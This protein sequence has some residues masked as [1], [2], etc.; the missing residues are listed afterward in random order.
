MFC[1]RT[2]TEGNI[3]YSGTSAV[4]GIQDGEVKVYGLLGRGSKELLVVNTDAVPYAKLVHRPSPSS[5]GPQRSLDEAAGNI[6][7][8]RQSDL[9]LS[10]S[11]APPPPDSIPLR[12]RS[13]NLSPF[14]VH[15]SA[16]AKSDQAIIPEPEPAASRL[17]LPSGEAGKW[18]KVII[19][20]SGSRSAQ[21]SCEYSAKGKNSEACQEADHRTHPLLS[22]P[23][24]KTSKQNPRPPEDSTPYPYSHD[25]LDN[26]TARWDA[27]LKTV[28]ARIDDAINVNGQV[29]NSKGSSHSVDNWTAAPTR[30]KSR[31]PSRSRS[32]ARSMSMDRESNNTI[33]NGQDCERSK[34]ALTQ[35]QDVL[36]SQ[37]VALKPNN[38]D[39]LLQTVTGRGRAP[40]RFS[41]LD[42]PERVG[43]PKRSTSADST[44]NDIL[45]R[46]DRNRDQSNFVRRSSSQPKF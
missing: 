21:G 9:R 44:R 42:V 40:K 11:A 1:N 15:D 43:K 35:R 32:H 26:H 37:Q 7:Y 25:S 24:G 19:P 13:S 28:Q 20:Q 31:R 41:A 2:G 17:I 6:L 10:H 23:P 39:I 16:L 3:T 12:L 4:I 30:P 29:V 27:Q 18:P 34:A 45:H 14:L 36:F 33:S 22:A 5:D 8:Q 38:P 46:R